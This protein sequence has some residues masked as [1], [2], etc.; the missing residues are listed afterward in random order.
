VRVPPLRPKLNLYGILTISDDESPWLVFSIG[1]I[2]NCIKHSVVNFF[3]VLHLLSYS[4]DF[5][6]HESC[7]VG[8][9]TLSTKSGLKIGLPL[10]HQGCS[11]LHMNTGVHLPDCVD[12]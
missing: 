8:L 3:L 5:I 10:I 7:D 4:S 2:L 12:D 1:Q 9:A 6:H 11:F